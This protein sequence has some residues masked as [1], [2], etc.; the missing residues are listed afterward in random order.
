MEEK[1]RLTIAIDP[2]HGYLLGIKPSGAKG[3]DDLVYSDD[4]TNLGLAQRLGHH[5]RGY[6]QLVCLTRKKSYVTLSSRVFSA[7]ECDADYFISLHANASGSYKARGMEIYIDNADKR[8]LELAERIAR[9]L[10]ELTGTYGIPFRG[11]RMDY[12]SQYKHLYV[13]EQCHSRGIAAVLVEAGFLTSLE[14]KMLLDNK[15]FR[16]EMCRLICHGILGK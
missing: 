8:S 15:V 1:K 4:S 9:N 7:I 12:Q 10:E 3:E 13:L 6:K 11:I 5:L 16:Q 2:G 14:D